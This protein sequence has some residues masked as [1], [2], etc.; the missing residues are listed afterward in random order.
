[1]NLGKLKNYTL[2]GQKLLLDFE[3][4]QASVAVITSKIINVYYDMGSEKRASKAIEGLFKNR[5]IK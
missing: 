1:M 3:G 5:N 2:E 4:G